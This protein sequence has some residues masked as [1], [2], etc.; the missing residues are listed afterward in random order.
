MRE[1]SADRERLRLALAPKLVEL[2]GPAASLALRALELGPP[3][4]DQ[5]ALARSPAEGR[6]QRIAEAVRQARAAAGRDAV[7]R[8]LE[9]EPDSRLPERRAIFTPYE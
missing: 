7:L 5:P 9:V 2:P 8:I 1:A 6:R 4:H 3:A